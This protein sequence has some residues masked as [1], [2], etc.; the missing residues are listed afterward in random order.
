MTEPFK[1]AMNTVMATS[2]G[3]GISEACREKA[4]GLCIEGGVGFNQKKGGGENI[5][6]ER[7]AW[8]VESSVWEGRE[9]GPRF[10]TY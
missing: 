6:V 7:I 8:N 9:H 2:P 3:L 1:D 5:P 4:I 10:A